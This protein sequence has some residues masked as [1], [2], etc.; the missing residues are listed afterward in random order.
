MQEVVKRVAV[1]RPRGT[2]A[3]QQET[4]GTV[5]EEE[6]AEAAPEQGSAGDGVSTR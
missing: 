1:V 5:Q 6:A 3:P 2:A 4:N